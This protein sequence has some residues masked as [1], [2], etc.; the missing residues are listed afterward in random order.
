MKKAIILA[1][2]STE[3]QIEGH[4][5]PA[6]L[7]RAIQY[8]RYKELLVQSKHQF[9]ESSLKDKR[10]K[11]E[12]VVHEI[13]S[14]N[15]P[16]ALIVE[17]ID[18][19]Q[20]DFKVSVLFD[21]YRK[22]GKL[23]IHFIRENLVVNKESNSSEL[24]RWDMG[25]MFARSYVLQIS[26][27]VKRSQKHKIA[28]GEYPGPGPYGYRNVPKENGS[29]DIQPEP[30]EASVIKKIFK[31]YA[32]GSYSMDEV[33]KKI[34]EEFDVAIHKG[35]IDNILK[36][37]F[38]HGTMRYNG[39][40]HPHGYETLISRE[41]FDTVQQ[42]KKSYG[43]KPFKHAGLPYLYRGLIKCNDCGCLFTPEKKKKKYVYYH[44]TEYKGKHGTAWIRE[45]DLTDQFSKALEDIK[46]PDNEIDDICSTLRASHAGK[47]DYRDTMYKQFTSEL[48]RYG[49][50]IESM[51][52]DKLDGLITQK[53]YADK[54]S[55]YRA[56]QAELQNKL[57]NL[58]K[59]DEDY[60]ISA[61]YILKLA[62]RASGLFKSS[63]PKVKRQILKLALQNCSV[64]DA[65]LSF[66]YRSPFSMFAKGASRQ[67]W[68]LG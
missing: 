11:F 10:T 44:C 46:I 22:Q 39:A 32:T 40:L 66:T 36:N 61:E 67:N 4:S 15:E 47:K 53:Y 27:N 41:I 20:R 51:Y 55:A 68:L 43:K 37:P 5:I 65:N 25:V 21:E 7:E 19:L 64:K 13:E 8:C 62:N 18:R 1:R 45:E 17:T 60:Y 23:E 42:I 28:K 59:A 48:E 63:E 34:R 9:D 16:I 30:F 35:K 26:D 52:E 6:Q 14:S 12:A 29:K 3:E 50:R 58:Q 54:V 57:D 38:Y 49:K 56:K 2:V 24:I 31:L 33:R